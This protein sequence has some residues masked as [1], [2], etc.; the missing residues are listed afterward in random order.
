MMDLLM[1]ILLKTES[2]LAEFTI[3]YLEKV[4]YTDITHRPNL[5]V[6]AQ[7][8][9]P[10]LLVAHLDTV[11]KNL[12]EQII[13]ET[14]YNELWSYEGIGG[15]DRAGVYAILNICK[16]FKPH[17]L[18]CYAEEQYAI[19]AHQASIDLKPNVNY[20]IELD[21]HGYK[22]AI[23]YEC[24]NEKFKKYITDFGFEEEYGTFTDI[25]ILAP[26]WDM[27]A[28]NLSIGF[29]REHTTQEYINLYDLINTIEKV[30]NI[31][32]EPQL[33][34]YNYQKVARCYEIEKYTYWN[35][36]WYD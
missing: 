27:A 11:H 5:Y 17:I 34:F 33:E 35:S 36:Y 10:V 15:D 12:P 30:K 29:Y 6:Y 28:V 20:I 18:F 25:S 2:E 13:Y 9:I 32:S 23:F 22:D 31:L 8:E 26:A 3:S 1:Q 21:R 24:G 16:T 7:G 4:G 14:A 19:G